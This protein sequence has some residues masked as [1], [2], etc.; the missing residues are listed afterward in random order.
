MKIRNAE[1][2]QALAELFNKELQSFGASPLSEETRSALMKEPARTMNNNFIAR[3]A[4]VS[5]QTS[6][7]A[8]FELHKTATQ[9]N[10]ENIVR[11]DRWYKGKEPTTGEALARIASISQKDTARGAMLWDAFAGLQK[12]ASSPF[13]NPYTQAT[14]QAIQQLAALGADVSGG[15]NDAWF[16]SYAF[17]KNHYRIGVSGSPLAPSSDST[18]LQ[19]AAYWYDK[20]LDAETATKKAET[21]W[22]AL[23]EEIA[24]WTNRDDL[25]L[26]DEEILSRIGWGKYS[27]LV[28]LDAGKASGQPVILNRAIDYDRDSLLGVIWAARNGTTGSTL[29]DS[30]MAATGTGN[31][32]KE[33]PEITDKLNPKSEKFSPYSVGSTM[34]DAALYFGVSEFGKDWLEKNRQYLAGNDDTA[35]KYYNQVYT[36]EQRTQKA[37]S[38]LAELNTEIDDWLTFTDDPN[39]I[40]D[41][42]LD[43]YPTL[44]ALDESMKNGKLLDTTRAIDYRW[45]DIES[46]V[47][48]RCSQKASAEQVPAFAQDVTEAL[49]GQQSPAKE[50]TP[51]PASTPAPAPPPAPASSAT[52]EP[53]AAGATPSPSSTPAPLTTNP[54]Y[55]ETTD[56]IAAAQTAAIRDAAPTIKEQGTP[57]EKISLQTAYS[58]NFLAMMQQINRAFMNGIAT[59][60][61]TADYVQQQTDSYAAKHYL[62]D[63][64]ITAPFEAQ[65]AEIDQTKAQLAEVEKALELDNK[66]YEHEGNSR[67]K[68]PWS[69]SEVVEINGRLYDL[70]ADLNPETGT[71]DSFIEPHYEMDFNKSTDLTAEE[72]AE[73]YAEELNATPEAEKAPSRNVAIRANRDLYYVARFTLQEDGTYAPDFVGRAFQGKDAIPSTMEIIDAWEAEPGEDVKAQADRWATE[74]GDFSS[75]AG[76]SF[77]HL[78]IRDKGK[79][80]QQKQVLVEKIAQQQEELEKQRPAYEKANA[81]IQAI[82]EGYKIAALISELSSG[83]LPDVSNYKSALSALLGSAARVDQA[84][85]LVNYLD[86]LYEEGA[87]YK[88]TEWAA[89]S[90]FDSAMDAGYTAQEVSA[91]AR[92]TAQQDRAAL[93]RLN[94]AEAKAKEAG[95]DIP[96]AY[97]R[98]IQREKARLQR[99][100]KEADYFR[101]QGQ[102]DFESVVNE[103]KERVVS[104]FD[105]KLNSPNVLDAMWNYMREGSPYARLLVAAKPEYATLTGTGDTLL[106][107][108]NMQNLT[109]RERNTY[110]YLYQKQGQEAADAYYDFLTDP[111]YGIVQT[112]V[113]QQTDAQLAQFAQNYP[114][115]AFGLSILASPSRLQGEA[116]SLGVRLS[117]LL[118]LGGDQEINP[119]NEAYQGSQVTGTLRGSSKE[120]ILSGLE[121]GSTGYWLADKGLDILGS[122]G[123]S[124]L[125][126]ILT[127]PFTGGIG[128]AVMQAFT[129]ASL[130]GLGAAGD[131]AR[132]VK[133]RGGTDQQA[134]IVAG[135]T[136]IAETATEAITYDNITEAVNGGAKE[137]K[138]LLKEMLGNM[139][140]EA[141]GEGAAEVIEGLTDKYVMGELSHFEQAVA[142]YEKTMSH[143]DAVTRAWRDFAVDVLVAA[144]SGAV[145]SVGTSGGGYV[146]GRVA[147]QFSMRDARHAMTQQT[148]PEITP[149]AVETGE[150]RQPAAEESTPEN[151]ETEEGQQAAP[152]ESTSDTVETGEGQAPESEKITSEDGKTGEQEQGSESPESLENPAF[153]TGEEAE[154]EKITSTDGIFGDSEEVDSTNGITPE[155]TQNIRALYALT[156]S[157]NADQASQTAAIGAALIPTQAN[158]QN[159]ATASAAAQHLVSTYG[160]TQAVNLVRQVLTTAQQQ[161]AN[162][163]AVK[164]ALTVAALG[165]GEARF[166]L[167]SIAL[168]G[169]SE[170]DIPNLL[171]A[172]N[173]D[174]TNATVLDQIQETVAA[175]QVAAEELALIGDGAL[176]GLQPYEDNLKQARAKAQEAEGRL[177]EAVAQ[178]E[179]MG[180][181]LQTVTGQYLADPSNQGMRGAVQQATKDVVGQAKVVAEYQQSLSNAQAAV[182]Q[183]QD[184]LNTAR[185]T[186]MKDV[187][188]QALANVQQAR[189]AMTRSVD[190]TPVQAYNNDQEVNEDGLQRGGI[191]QAQGADRRE[192]VA[193]SGRDDGR[194]DNVHAG[195][196]P[197]QETTGRGAEGSAEYHRQDESR[198]PAR[199]LSKSAQ[200]NLAQK[201]VTDLHLYME[202]DRQRF[203]DALKQ[204]KADNAH[205]AYVDAQSVNDLEEKGAKMIIS[206]DSLAGVAVGTK[207]KDEGNI[208]AVFKDKRSKAKKASVALIIQALAQGGDKLDC[209]D[210]NLRSMY[211]A[212]GMIP[213]ARVAFNENFAPP[214]WNMARDD[215]PDIVFWMHNGDSA[216][217][218]AEKYGLA[219]EEGG[220]HV[221]TDDDIAALPLFGDVTNANGE[222]E[223]GYDRAWDYRDQLLRDAKNQQNGESGI[224]AYKGQKPPQGSGG[225]GEG[226]TVTPKGAPKKSPQRI[227]KDLVKKLGIGQYVGTKKM[228]NLPQ[229]VRGYY[230]QRAKYIAVR[231]RS[232]GDYVVDMHEIGHAIADRL[233]MTGT[234]D[235]IANLDPLFAANY[236]AA[237]LP[238]EAFAEFMWRYMEDEQLGR[239]FAGDSF[240]DSFERA[241]QDNGLAKDVHEAASQLRAWINASTSDQIGATIHARSERPKLGLLEQARRLINSIVDA[242]NAAEAVNH[243]IRQRTGNQKVPFDQDVRA[244]SLLKNHASKRAFYILTE[245]MLDSS[246]SRTGG[247]SLKQALEKTGLTSKDVPLLERYMLAMHSL[248]RDNQNKPV[249]D[250][251]ITPAER[252]TFIDDVKQNHPQVARAEKA[253]QAWRKDFLQHFM[254]DTG[255]MEQ[256]FFDRLNQIY[257]HYVPTYRVKDERYQNLNH[258]GGKTYQIRRAT[259][260]T[261]DIWSPID[262]FISMVDSIVTMVSANN[263]ALAWNNA[264]SHNDLGEFGRLITPDVK[265]VTVD[266]TQVQEQVAKLLDRNVDDD[267]MQQV[268]DAIGEEQSQWITQHGSS[269]ANTITVQLPDGSRRYYEIAD[270]ELYKLLASIDDKSAGR[271]RLLAMAGALTRGM[272]ALTTGNNPV[273]AVRNFIRDF[274]NSV[275]YGSWASNY[276]TGAAKWLR[277]AYDVWKHDGEYEDYAALGGGGWTRI[278]PG[279]T[280]GAAEYR[281][282]MYKGY[283]TENVGHTA[284]YAGKKLWNAIT[285]NR[286]NE[287]VEQT[288]RYAEYKYGKHDKSTAEGRAQA[289]LAGQEATVD[290]SRSGN[291]AVAGTL[292]QLI[293]FFNAS[294]Q[295]VYR[296]GR[297]LTEAERGRAAVRFTKTIVNTAILSALCNALLIKNSDDDEKEEFAY[298]SDKLKSQHFYL[299]NFAPHVL[300]QQPLIRIPLAQDPLTYAVHGAVTNAMW[301]G[302]TD[303]AMIDLAAIADTILDNLNPLG[304]GTIFQPMIGIGQN[305]NWYGSRIVPSRMSEWDKSSQYTEET[306]DVF[307][308]VSRAIGSLS[309]N[310]PLASP[311]NLQYLAEQYTGFLGQMAIPALSKNKATG[312]LGGWRAALTGAQKRLTSDPLISNDVLNSFYDGASLL[313]QVTNAAKN[314]RPL[315]MLRRGL[316]AE[317]ATA[318]Y[319]EAKELTSSGGIIYETK[320]TINDLYAEIDKINAN[321]TLTDEQK[322]TLTSEARKEM[323]AA[324]L[325]AQEAI[326]A[327][328][329]KYITGMNVAT[330]MLFAG[331]TAHIPTTY[332]KLPQ[333]FRDD[334]DKTYMQWAKAVYDA[335]GADG[336]LPHPNT[337]F[338][339]NKTEYTVGPE[340]MDNYILKYKAAYQK[341]LA[342]NGKKWGILSD[343]DRLELLRNAHTA[344]HNAAKEWYRK[345]HGIK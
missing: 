258:T 112:R 228:N 59:N 35:K 38:E 337:T 298:L 134:A 239:H 297:M 227:A 306:P 330:N 71:F 234:P 62:A 277:S 319:E 31:T 5:R 194:G 261:E 178:Q 149:D 106:P 81:E 125:N 110:I 153:P 140:E 233:G 325:E 47:R 147:D 210:G 80:F 345:L 25:N 52:P 238:G 335:T 235:M 203:S 86:L 14:N 331:A 135:A 272:A 327:F 82:R 128:S 102:A 139:G 39:V 100:I 268:L 167:Q 322:Y 22:A 70:S 249:V 193:A 3:A 46:L 177:K 98:N 132:D 173:N 20:L 256:A 288:S 117:E 99:N 96:E 179:V 94:D 287:I 50:A 63:K 105:S 260:A 246:W 317:E 56:A 138:S 136:F 79:L 252:Q 158:D 115:A 286:L 259:G 208:F 316:T 183:A 40:L 269:L 310:S 75:Y 276:L 300:G 217:T 165:N 137:A 109:E 344:G 211:Q 253:F 69:P 44:R 303:G 340:D 271:N 187:R 157:L 41:G 201:G 64:Q 295:G 160:S 181:N 171:Y 341:Y 280:K 166:N 336:A 10:Q 159:T 32:W 221:Y 191:Y 74:L 30:V 263:A 97:S 328:R 61:E 205:G 324:T 278:E 186:T 247:D 127:A 108:V 251:H 126:N 111:S 281:E 343:E 170:N 143:E 176:A 296:T 339:Y 308:E 240:V 91:I 267:L 12:D 130:M 7:E 67:F 219:E 34:D 164:N 305:K 318:A 87:E 180:A 332:E 264:Y 120:K 151:V 27:T 168:L 315:N 1:E 218:V 95:A 92:V 83:V 53:S 89:Y 65:Q 202:T 146:A 123:E 141:L 209:Y 301:N 116:Y 333:T 133:L 49:N 338:S 237:E 304:S 11:Q 241:L 174:L 2:E 6:G 289:F 9:K 28:S 220:Y 312:E 279:T 16:E 309:P 154:P 57:E 150:A 285:L 58:S 266:T 199:L 291:G 45:Q 231:N 236:S 184:A 36:A 24:Y 290:F 78:D 148:I 172:A 329:E 292:K 270:T 88:A 119:Y 29:T 114:V 334:E 230:E 273:F 212:V 222:T 314:E 313:T 90:A 68:N 182:Q 77:D 85:A 293:P 19:D 156:A 121:E 254:V 215:H 124:T 204:A 175:S 15:I 248:D 8:L 185:E 321:D 84:G 107:S 307:V 232:A 142:E 245:G 33:N 257:P 129:G 93:K 192:L 122:I 155:S 60:Q 21:E 76:M 54:A 196:R 250:A 48:E 103:A 262:S 294:M 18:A 152:E 274:Q 302:S 55:A 282:A 326:G 13:Y 189:N 162:L 225:T 118:G 200:N 26:S 242:S 283:N 214:G 23:K 42:L 244:N 104:E 17:L 223:Y 161:N 213:V 190:S 284:K 73:K 198:V 66:L 145:S 163:E 51:T 299:P 265:Q 113:S 4:D 342:T 323:I 101:L 216:N 195:Q 169:M 206:E 144:A 72:A 226:Q 275:N 311:M 255:Y 197:L 243:K 37:E 224:Q 207:G 43:D 188:Q 320:K 229:Q 131:A